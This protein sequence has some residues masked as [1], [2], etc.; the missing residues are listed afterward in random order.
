MRFNKLQLDNIRRYD[1]EQINIPKSASTIVISGENGAGKSTILR[2]IA[3]SIFQSDG[4]E[5][6]RIADFIRK[7]SENGSIELELNVKG[8]NHSLGW[9]I[10]ERGTK[11]CRMESPN[12]SVSGVQNVESKVEGILGMEAEQFMGSA[13]VGQKSVDNILHQRPKDR[14]DSINSLLGIDRVSDVRDQIHDGTIKLDKMIS[15]VDSNISQ[16]ED[17]IGDTNED[18]LIKSKKK[19]EEEKE[20]IESDIN[21]IENDI[22]TI[23]SRKKTKEKKIDQYEEKIDKREELQ[24]KIENEESKVEELR[25]RLEDRKKEKDEIEERMDEIESNLG[26]SGI[27]LNALKSETSQLSSEISDLT[28]QLNDLEEK[29]SDITS[30]VQK[31]KE[32]KAKADSRVEN[33]E[34]K[35]DSKLSSIEKI[36][37]DLPDYLPVDDI[38]EIESQLKRTVDGDLIRTVRDK[39]EDQKSDLKKDL[40]EQRRT[41][42][43]IQLKNDQ[44]NDLVETG[45][46]PVCES[47]HDD[48]SRFEDLIGDSNQAES[49]L[50][51]IEDKISLVDK[52]LEELSLVEDVNSLRG[53]LSSKESKQESIVGDIEELNDQKDDILDRIGTIEDE[54]RS[55]EVLKELCE[56]YMELS[57]NLDDTEDLIR[58]TEDLVKDSFER[59]EDYNTKI[60]NIDIE[61]DVSELRSDINKLEEALD[62]AEEELENKEDRRDELTTRVGEIENQIDNL[63]EEKQR[64]ERLVQKNKRFRRKNSEIQAVEQELDVLEEKLRKENVKKL[65]NL[66]NEVLDETHAREDIQSV[67]LDESED[68]SLK[69]KTGTDDILSVQ[70]LSGGQETIVGLAFK[71]GVYRLMSARTDS[72]NPPLM[73][74]EPTDSLDT[75]HITQFRELVR[76][77]PEW[78]IQQ[79]IIVTHQQ[80][81]TSVADLHIHVNKKQNG[82]SEIKYR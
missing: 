33:T 29:K 75:E 60:D 25:G 44:L 1:Q 15:N 21:E 49:K 72:P 16:I 28:D 35:I 82:L 31:K 20:E 48:P 55:K 68:Y 3:G 34:D 17:K 24:K 41:V 4:L 37:Y 61:A 67:H 64:K 19:T 63:R 51:D 71:I 45:V 79:S 11:S 18:D 40:R 2:A 12:T 69:V 74:D 6:L 73:L 78:N 77:L 14:V 57:D 32:N 23:E 26:Q 42:E 38:S 56:E 52:L 39:L 70:N 76:S 80:E 59:L 58:D 47:N 13:Y 65:L 53:K 10:H 54:I 50:S 66:I 22:D 7:G 9:D 43:H 5:D 81:I 27:D 36:N 30:E 8:G 62:G 46:C